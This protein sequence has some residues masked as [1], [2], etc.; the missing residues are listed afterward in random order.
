MNFD[1][2]KEA[3]DKEA[4]A[5]KSTEL[6]IDLGK[7]KQNPVSIIRRNMWI[8]LLTIILASIAFL[9]VPPL[10]NME[11]K[12]E[13]IYII[14]M[15]ICVIMLLGNGIKF[16]FFLKES[17]PLNTS[18][19]RTIQTFICNAKSTIAVYKTFSISTALLIPVPIFALILGQSSS[20]YYN[21]ELFQK[22]LF[23]DLSNKE[24]INFVGLYIAFS[25]MFYLAIIIWIKYFYNKHILQLENL[26]EQLED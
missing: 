6:K 19:V 15:T 14:F 23:L 4:K 16:S 9:C 21:P 1:K 8:E 18:T 7:G 26:L 12:T 13:S 5:D 25:A 24:I 17:V 11:A 20:E 10:Y 22:Y 2:I 3:M